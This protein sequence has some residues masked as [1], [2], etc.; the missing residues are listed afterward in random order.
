MDIFDTIAPSGEWKGVHK[1]RLRMFYG[2]GVT[3]AHQ[4]IVMFQCLQ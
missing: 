1:T 2:C 3:A 4:V